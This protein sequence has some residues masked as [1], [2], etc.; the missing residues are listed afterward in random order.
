MFLKN[1]INNSYPNLDWIQV[2]ISSYCNAGCIYCPRT[3]Y[4]EDWQNRYLP[5]DAFRNLKPA[6][7]KTE[8]VYLQGWGDP[9]THPRFFEMLQLAKRAGC[10]VGTTTNGTLLNRQLIE[11]LVA[12]DLDVIGFSL[13]G[14]DEKNDEIRK[15]TPI[16]SVLSSIEELHR[17]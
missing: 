17:A 15:G 12:E 11:K 16:K 1:L 14:I 13:A 9:F 3:V 7:R 8:L 5:I 2:E 10:R 4:R 6:F